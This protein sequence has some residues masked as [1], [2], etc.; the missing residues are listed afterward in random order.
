MPIVTLA[1]C[2]ADNPSFIKMKVTHLQI[3]QVIIFT[4]PEVSS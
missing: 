4:L 3:F 1:I 2:A